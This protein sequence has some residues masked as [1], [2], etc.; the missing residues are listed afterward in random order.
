MKTLLAILFMGVSSVC[1]T[2]I[3]TIPTHR[4]DWDATPMGWRDINTGIYTNTSYVCG[5]QANSGQ[6]DSSQD[7]YVVAYDSPANLLTYTIKTTGNT[8]ST[9]LVEESTNGTNW[10]ALASQTADPLPTSCTKFQ[11]PIQQSSRFLRFTYNKISQNLL[12]DDVYIEL[13]CSAEL[14]ELSKTCDQNTR[15]T[16]Q[17]STKIEFDA[18]YESKPFS[19]T[20]TEG[21]ISPTTLT[22]SGI[23]TITGVN[24]LV[25]FEVNAS[26]GDLCELNIPIT[27]PACE[28]LSLTAGEGPRLMITGVI[29]GPL[30]GNLP[31]AIELYAYDDIENLGGYYIKRVSNGN[32]GAGQYFYFPS[33]SSVSRGSFIYLEQETDLTSGTEFKDFFGFPADFQITNRFFAFNGDDSFHLYSENCLIDQF[34]QASYTGPASWSHSQGWAVRKPNSYPNFGNFDESKWTITNSIWNGETNNNGANAM[35]IQSFTPGLFPIYNTVSCR[36][37]QVQDCLPQDYWMPI[38]SDDQQI[39]AEIKDG[40]NSLNSVK[41]SVYLSATPREDYDGTNYLNR[42]LY[43]S[44]LDVIT[45]SAQPKLR[46][47]FTQNEF[48]QLVADSNGDSDGVQNLSDLMITH[49]VN[50]SNCQSEYDG[51]IFREEILPEIYAYGANYYAEFSVAELAGAYHLHGGILVLPNLE[52]ELEVKQNSSLSHTIEGQIETNQELKFVEL[53]RKVGSNSFETVQQQ[54]LTQTKQFQFVDEHRS[55]Q[56]QPIIYRVIC[57]D[58]LN[59]IY[60]SKSIQVEQNFDELVYNSASKSLMLPKPVG[61]LSIYSMIGELVFEINSTPT[62]M[63]KLSKLPVGIYIARF[64][65]RYTVFHVF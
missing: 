48:D 53:Q 20:T 61:Q 62:T 21:S 39:I 17:Y 41:A 65:E 16:D 9:F 19:F 58:R 11:L 13:G 46:F 50:Q 44:N 22:S 26:D 34:G 29:D 18:G 59:R 55:V 14:T 47:Y 30:A 36:P 6:M 35:P 42:S 1:F 15:F 4:S 5:N 56:N 38:L 12:L 28:P 7:Q 23:L 64:D 31:K 51:S 3:A 2:Q 32:N 43:I 33:T 63:V 27:A 40:G 24:E 57:I 54:S 60:Y 8:S 45:Q 10:F 52:I 25:D 49:E 37:Y